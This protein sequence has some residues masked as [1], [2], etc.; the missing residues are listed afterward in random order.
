MADSTRPN[1]LRVQL[2]ASVMRV[3]RGHRRGR[4]NPSSPLR[5]MEKSARKAYIWERPTGVGSACRPTPRPRFWSDGFQAAKTATGGQGG[6]AFCSC[7]FSQ[8]G[9]RLIP[10]AVRLSGHDR[11]GANQTRSRRPRTKPDRSCRV[12]PH[13]HRET[14][15]RH[16][17]CAVGARSY[18][19]CQVTLMPDN[20]RLSGTNGAAVG[21][22]RLRG[23]A[24]R[25]CV[26]CR[27]PMTI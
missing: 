16:A 22:S 11:P 5:A 25:P 19:D 7:P 24:T 2:V 8:N 27:L 6:T 15:F 4:V 1:N 17:A 20:G 13:A 26:A 14:P 18:G 23:Y 12:C 3:G 9:D 21:F 10:A